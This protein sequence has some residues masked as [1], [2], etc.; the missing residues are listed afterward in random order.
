MPEVPPEWLRNADR[1]SYN[2]VRSLFKAADEVGSISL[3]TFFWAL[4]A[5]SD[6]TLRRLFGAADSNPNFKEAG[7]GDR[8]ERRFQHVEGRTMYM[9]VAA[10]ISSAASL[11]APQKFEGIDLL[12]AFLQY[13]EEPGNDGSAKM[14]LEHAGIDWEILSALV[15]EILIYRLNSEVEAIEPEKKDEFHL[16]ID[17]GDASPEVVGNVLAALSK[18]NRACGGNGLIFARDNSQQPI[19]LCNA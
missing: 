7:S 16:W 8:A 3:R 4:S 6:H 5:D 19:I 10:L 15:T 9:N 13:T 1:R 12:S 17:P 18:L 11:R 14:A 2:L